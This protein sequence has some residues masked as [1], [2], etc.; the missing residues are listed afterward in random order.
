MQ[1]QK[2]LFTLFLIFA[3]PLLADEISTF[4]D[5]LLSQ[6]DEILIDPASQELSEEEKS[7][8]RHCLERELSKCMT[9]ICSYCS[10]PGGCEHCDHPKHCKDCPDGCRMNPGRTGEMC[11][12]FCGAKVAGECLF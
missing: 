12:D 1:L 8:R 2:T 10:G 4:D 5:I 11:A 9:E 6:V 7:S 3:S